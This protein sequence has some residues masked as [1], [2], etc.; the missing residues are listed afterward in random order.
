MYYDC[1]KTRETC[2]KIYCYIHSGVFLCFYKIVPRYSKISNFAYPVPEITENASPYM[3]SIHIIITLETFS[4]V[5]VH[6]IVN[7]I[8]TLTLIVKNRF[9][10]WVDIFLG[11]IQCSLFNHGIRPSLQFLV[12]ARVASSDPYV[13]IFSF[14]FLCAKK[15]CPIARCVF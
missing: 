2:V 13:G 4:N 8:L 15:R 7:W 12:S 10:C 11:L 1:N 9:K 5:H 6:C 3:Y 14:P